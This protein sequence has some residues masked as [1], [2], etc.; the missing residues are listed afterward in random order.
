MNIKGTYIY[1]PQIENQINNFRMLTQKY[2]FDS[3]L[4]INS[5]SADKVIS[6]FS[7]LL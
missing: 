2:Q 6:A 5:I 7:Q 3:D 1:P 4:D